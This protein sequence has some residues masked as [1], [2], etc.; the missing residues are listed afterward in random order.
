MIF[1]RPD[2]VPIKCNM[3]P[4]IKYGSTLDIVA[5]YGD[6]LQVSCDQGFTL[7]DGHD[8]VRC[9]ES[10]LWSVDTVSCQPVTCTNIR[11]LSHGHVKYDATSEHAH[12]VSTLAKFSCNPGYQLLGPKNMTCLSSGLWSESLPK[13]QRKYLFLNFQL[14]KPVTRCMVPVFGSTSEYIHDGRGASIWRYCEIF[15]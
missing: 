15:L 14:P 12:R 6:K 8:E 5:S 3:P 4:S 7:E 1:S 10:G 11:D 13:C 2:C 9:T